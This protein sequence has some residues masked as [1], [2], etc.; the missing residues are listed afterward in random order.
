M[1]QQ[2]VYLVQMYFKYESTKK[3]RRKFRC[4][5][6][7][8]PVRCRQTIHYVVN[9]LTT[10]GS[11]VEKTYADRYAKNI[12][13]SFLA[14]IAKEEKLYF[15]FQQDSV[16]AYTAH[17]NLEELRK[18]VDARIISR[19]LWPPS[20]PDLTPCDFYLWGSLEDK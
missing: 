14:E 5:F 13:R 12:V 7:G 16:M 9:K 8:E 11:M 19:R 10:T 3:C 20:S 17:V 4:Q 1:A 6:P 15:Y 18:V 2:S